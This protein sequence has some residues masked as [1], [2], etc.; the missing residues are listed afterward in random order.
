MKTKPTKNIATGLQF[1][2]GI[3]LAVALA[4]PAV[5]R[6]QVVMTANDAFGASSFN[7]AG[8]W[9]PSAAPSAGKTYS[10]QGYLLRSPTTA[11]S[12]TFAGDSLTVGGG[13]GGGAFSPTTANNN[14]LIFKASGLTLTV[15]NLILDGSQIRDGN[16]DGSWTAL[17]GNITVTAN[18]GSFIAQDTNIVNSAISG[19]GPIYIGDNGSGTSPRIIVFTSGSST[20]DGSIIMDNTHGNANYSRLWFTAGSIMNFM[21]GANGVNNGISGKGTLT[22]DGNFNFNLAGAD[23]TVGDSWDIVDTAVVTTYDSTFAVNG[24]AQNGTEWNDVANGVNYNFS[25]ATG[26]LTVQAVPEPASLAL[27]GLGGFFTLVT[28]MRRKK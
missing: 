10:T 19:S 18:G 24:F 1:A 7:T 27:C 2:M 13:S 4:T 21:I 28:L 23:N 20:Y 25:Q 5:S 22:L 16:G 17:D 3:A 15:N 14:A 8:T 9:S 26:L 12:Y 11:G 6:A